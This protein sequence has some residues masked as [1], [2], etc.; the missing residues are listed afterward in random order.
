MVKNVWDKHLLHSNNKEAEAFEPMYSTPTKRELDDPMLDKH[1]EQ[2]ID[3]SN[4]LTQP[5]QTYSEA[6]Q[7]QHQSRQDSKTPYIVDKPKSMDNDQSTAESYRNDDQQAKSRD[8]ESTSVIERW[9]EPINL[10]NTQRT[11][12]RNHA[13]LPRN[14]PTTSS[15]STTESRIIK[16]TVVESNPWTSVK[17]QQRSAKTQQTEFLTPTRSS[18]SFE[19]PPKVFKNNLS[20]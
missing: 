10:P 20:N 9:S 15:P 3:I 16:Q 6:V 13:E 1:I 4:P 14:A 2:D 19:E 12:D 18:K 8:K 7:R 5:H 17:R 11:M